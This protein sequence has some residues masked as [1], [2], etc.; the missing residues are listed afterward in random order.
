MAWFLCGRN[1]GRII[2]NIELYVSHVGIWG[3]IL[4][5]FTKWAEWVRQTFSYVL[6]RNIN[7]IIIQF[8]TAILGH[9]IDLYLEYSRIPLVL[10]LLSAFLLCRIII[11]KP[12]RNIRRILLNFTKWAEWVRKTSSYV[13]YRMYRRPFLDIKFIFQ[14]QTDTMQMGNLNQWPKF[15]PVYVAKKIFQGLQE[16]RRRENGGITSYFASVL[17]F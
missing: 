15:S 7:N 6:Y 13:V 9:K 1:V 8:W 14:W 2:K 17:E 3:R 11:H 4:I 12:K 5:K 16:N 10:A